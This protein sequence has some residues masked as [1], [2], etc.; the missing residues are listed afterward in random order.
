MTRNRNEEAGT[1]PWYCSPRRNSSFDYVLRKHKNGEIIKCYREGTMNMA[2]KVKLPIGIENFEKIRK[3][4]FYYVDKTGLIS[5]LLD[6]WGEVNLFTRPR[7]F[8]KSLNMS[9]DRKSVV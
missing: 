4:G 3:E 5:E 6:N 2:K 1:L 7:R 9:I 8:G